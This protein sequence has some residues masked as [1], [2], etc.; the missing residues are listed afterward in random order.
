MKL[1][2]KI[3]CSTRIF[4]AFI[5]WVRKKSRQFPRNFPRNFPLRYQ[6][7]S[8]T[9]FCRRAGRIFTC[10]I[11]W[12]MNPVKF[13]SRVIS[14]ALSLSLSLFLFL[15][16]TCFEIARGVPEARDP[17]HQHLSQRPWLACR[18]SPPVMQRHHHK[19]SWAKGSKPRNVATQHL[20]RSKRAS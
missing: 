9:S 14:L 16:L 8:Q 15:F 18:F 13:P 17:P 10:E 20:L 3:F 12:A 4:W 7:K 6:K 11:L 19:R 1:A 5:L 2:R